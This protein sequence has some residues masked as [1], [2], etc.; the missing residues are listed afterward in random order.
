MLSEVM[1]H[2]VEVVGGL[3]R[4]TPMMSTMLPGYLR[5]V[6]MKPTT[7]M[8]ISCPRPVQVITEMSRIPSFLWTLLVRPAMW[9]RPSSD[10]WE[11]I[12]HYVPSEKTGV[13]V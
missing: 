5:R 11:S 6:L 1:M 13:G 8:K 12:A 2:V 4:A 9:M 3:V 7:L 10:R